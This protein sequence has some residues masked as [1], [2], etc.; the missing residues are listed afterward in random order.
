MKIL[1]VEDEKPIADLID[2]SLTARGY[3]C[4]C[5][6]D[7]AAAADLLV[8]KRFDL[9]LLDVM[10]PGADGFE[11]LEY[12]RPLNMP[13]IFLTARGAVSDRVRG[14]REGADDYIVKPFETLELVAR[15]QAVLRRTMKTGQGVFRVDDVAI[16]FDAKT[17]TRGGEP[18]ELTPQ[19]Y[20][21]LE[22]LAINRNLALSREKILDKAWNV[23]GFYGDIRTVDVHV[24]RLRQKLGLEKRIKTVYKVGYRLEVRDEGE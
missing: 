8:E 6:Y 14:L 21:L 9:I 15:V 3:Q 20:A 11:L 10:L 19:E 5:V 17:V 2:M 7:G 12:I 13:V 22:A 24:S 16:D 1:I 18:V 23:N 4:T